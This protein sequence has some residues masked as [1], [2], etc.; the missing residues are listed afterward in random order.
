MDDLSIRNAAQFHT[1]SDLDINCLSGNYLVADIQA[2]RSENIT[3]LSVFIADQANTASSVRIV[4]N[5]LDCCCQTIELRSLEIDD[6]ILLFM[7]TTLM[8]TSDVSL[9]VSSTVLLECGEKSLLRSNFA[10]TISG[11]QCLVS[12]TVVCRSQCSYWHFF[13]LLYIG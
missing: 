4:F 1:I 5:C 10:Q 8:T 3:L 7:T 13:I 6:T 2:L 12:R 11:E 9:V